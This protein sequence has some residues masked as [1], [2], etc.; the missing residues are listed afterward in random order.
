MAESDELIRNFQFIVS[1][2]GEIAAFQ[3]VILPE[4]E[5]EVIEYRNGSDICSSTRKI[6]GLVKYSN[7]ILKRG[8]IKSPELHDWFKQAKQGTPERKDITVSIL[9]EEHEPFAIWR[10]RNCWPVK[11]SGPTLNA[12]GNEV[13]METLEIATEDV[14]METV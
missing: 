11:Y 10:L 8:L 5:I 9:N 13:A 4:S 1:L 7:L 2:G 14:D 12:K 3:E 6:P